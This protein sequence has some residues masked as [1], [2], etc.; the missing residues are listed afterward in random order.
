MTAIVIVLIYPLLV[1]ARLCNLV[2]GRDPLRLRKPAGNPFWIVREPTPSDA[3]YFSESSMVE[4]RNHRGLGWIA[5]GVLTW[6]ARASTPG[7]GQPGEKFSA[8]ADRE[9]GIPDETYTLW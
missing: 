3:S 5:A 4:G 8:A 6:A 2:L 9:H 1:A 7:R